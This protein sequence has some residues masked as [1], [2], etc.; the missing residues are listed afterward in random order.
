YAAKSQKYLSRIL[1]NQQEEMQE[2]CQNPPTEDTG[3]VL[4]F[5][6][7]YLAENEVGYDRGH[8]FLHKLRKSLK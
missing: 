7:N 3:K 8:L 4:R 1:Q 2:L 5:T 6:R